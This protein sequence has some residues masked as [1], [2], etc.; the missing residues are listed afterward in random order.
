MV[1]IEDIKQAK[2]RLDTIVRNTPMAYAPILSKKNNANIY[3][4][5]EN[6][7]LTGS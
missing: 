5:K 1:T 2:N 3:L 7:Q 4:K 6:L